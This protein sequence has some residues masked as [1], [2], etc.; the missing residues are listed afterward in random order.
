VKRVDEERVR[1]VAAEN[2]DLLNCRLAQRFGISVARL[3]KI[4]G[5]TGRGELPTHKD[6]ARARYTPRPGGSMLAA[7]AA[8]R[9][10]RSH[11]GWQRRQAELVRP[12]FNTE[13]KAKAALAPGTTPKIFR[14]R[15]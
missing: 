10:P 7:F 12:A 4:L 8:R 14:E 1:K 11:V 2:P 9:L 3:R 5:I 13:F 6:M 15:E